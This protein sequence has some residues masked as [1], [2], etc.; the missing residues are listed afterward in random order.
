[1]NRVRQC[2]TDC[3]SHIRMFHICMEM[4]G[5]TANDIYHAVSSCTNEDHSH[6]YTYESVMSS[7]AISPCTIQSAA[8][9]RKQLCSYERSHINLHDTKRGFIRIRLCSYEHSH[10]P[11]HEWTRLCSYAA[12]CIRA[13]SAITT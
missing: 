3:S 12:L 8:Y 9:V 1:M 6:I 13:A 5:A 4:A 7:T 10:I 11:L 2:D